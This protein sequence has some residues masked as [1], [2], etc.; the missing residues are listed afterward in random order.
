[1]RLVPL[2]AACLSLSAGG[3]KTLA[4]A[5]PPWSGEQSFNGLKDSKHGEPC[6]VLFKAEALDLCDGQSVPRTASVDYRYRDRTQANNCNALGFFCS[7]FD[8]RFL[9]GW[10]SSGD[11]ERRSF[12]IVFR[13]TKTAEEFNRVMARWSDTTPEEMSK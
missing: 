8:H 11:S 1:M 5:L 4:Q 6:K 2:I 9:I 7:F 13:N 12:T 10:R 3:G